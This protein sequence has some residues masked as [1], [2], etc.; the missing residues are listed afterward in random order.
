MKA[1]DFTLSKRSVRISKRLPAKT[2]GAAMKRLPLLLLAA[3]L[4]T[5][6]TAQYLTLSVDTELVH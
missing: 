5:I 4:S 2:P 3:L 1:P 6:A